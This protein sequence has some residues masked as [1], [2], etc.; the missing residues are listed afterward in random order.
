MIYTEDADFSAIERAAWLAGNAQ[1]AALAAAADDLAAQ[2][3][4]ER[5]R[6]EKERDDE[7]DRAE[8]A[9]E[10][11]ETMRVDLQRA[12]QAVDDVLADCKRISKRAELEAALQSVYQA[13]T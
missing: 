3:V 10:S 6:L 7:Y 13:T 4:Q 5:E 1:V 11:L 12:L 9:K 2:A 8:A